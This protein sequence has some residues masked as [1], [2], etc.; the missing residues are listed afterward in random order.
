MMVAGL[1]S[2]ALEGTSSGSRRVNMCY[3][4]WITQMPSR[5]LCTCFKGDWSIWGHILYDPKGKRL[6]KKKAEERNSKSGSVVLISGKHYCCWR[7]NG[8]SSRGSS[9]PWGET[10][11]APSKAAAFP[12]TCS[13]TWERLLCTWWWDVN[14]RYCSVIWMRERS[15]RGP[16]LNIAL[17]VFHPWACPVDAPSRCAQWMRGLFFPNNQ[18]I[19][20]HP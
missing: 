4:S 13:L 16:A 12:N 2:P 6:K 10:F 5:E 14:S 15:F 1:G 17:R 11:A 20:G 3:A 18:I 19:E 7:Q 9:D 8:V